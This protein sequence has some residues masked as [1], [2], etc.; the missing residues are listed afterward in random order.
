MKWLLMLVVGLLISGCGTTR[1]TY[2]AKS[3][4]WDDVIEAKSIAL[5]DTICKDH[6]GY[7]KSSQYEQW[8]DYDHGNYFEYINVDI[9]CYDGLTVNIPI[10]EIN[11]VVSPKVAEVLKQKGKE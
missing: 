9:V 3:Q 10:A 7:F 6:S 4:G 5:A 8:H 1:T 2:K 11:S